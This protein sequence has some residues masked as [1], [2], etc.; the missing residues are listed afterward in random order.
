ML[1]EVITLAELHKSN[2]RVRIIGERE[3]LT[4]DIGRLLVEAEDL[5]KDNDGLTLV[6][7]YNFV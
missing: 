2:V 6:V 3:D 7:S 4:P 1:Y 5:T